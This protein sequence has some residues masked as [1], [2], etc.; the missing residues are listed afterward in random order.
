LIEVGKQSVV[1]VI[2]W[3]KPDQHLRVV[4]RDWLKDGVR[5]PGVYLDME[6]M[7][8]DLDA[9]LRRMT[10]RLHEEK[11]FAR[12]VRKRGRWLDQKYTVRPEKDESLLAWRE[13]WE[14]F[15]SERRLLAD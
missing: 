12:L 4:A 3:K 7:W 1:V 14:A 10:R 6:T 5:R 2:A 9:F 13:V 8:K 11:K 15:L